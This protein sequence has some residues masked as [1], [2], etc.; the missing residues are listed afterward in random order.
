MKEWKASQVAE[1]R[2]INVWLEAQIADA[3][4]SL[5][6]CADGSHTMD[7]LEDRILQLRRMKDSLPKYL[8]ANT[9]MMRSHEALCP[10]NQQPAPSKPT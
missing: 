5:D 7:I 3:C 1:I 9:T 2:K 4:E 8:L 10:P 6:K